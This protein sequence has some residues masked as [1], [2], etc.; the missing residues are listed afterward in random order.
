MLQSSFL[1]KTKLKDKK[2]IARWPCHRGYI[3][4]YTENHREDTEHRREHSGSL[5]LPG[6]SLCNKKSRL[7]V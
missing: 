3:R 1:K 6:G 5:C 4:I 7:N 2:P